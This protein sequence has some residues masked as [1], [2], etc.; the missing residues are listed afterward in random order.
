[1]IERIF[2]GWDRPIIEYACDWLLENKEL[3]PEAWIVVPTV[4]SGRSLREVLISRA[5]AMLSPH[6]TTPGLMMQLRSP[7]IATDWQE[8]YAWFEIFERIDDW[9]PYVA[10]LPDPP[11][12]SAAVLKS[13]AD[14]MLNLRRS[15]QENGLTFT[16]AARQLAHT[17]AADRWQA[18]AKLESA[19]E[20]KLSG[21]DLTSRSRAL[22]NTALIPN[23]VERIMLIGI[24]E[25]SPLLDRAFNAWQ[26]NLTSLIAA[27]PHEAA[28]FSTIG[29]PEKS[30]A[31]RELS[32]PEKPSAVHLLINP[33]KQ[34]EKV[35][36]LLSDHQTEAKHAAIGSADPEVAHAIAID[37]SRAGWS[38]FH[39]GAAVP[40]SGIRRWLTLFNQWLI[41]DSIVPLADLFSQPMTAAIVQGN[42]YDHA[43]SLAKLRDRKLCQTTAA[44]VRHLKEDTPLKF[45][46]ADLDAWR[47]R[48]ASSDLTHH[49]SELL[50][51][52]TSATPDEQNNSIKPI[53]TWLEESQPFIKASPRR[54]DFWIAWM[55]DSLPAETASPPPHRVIDVQGWLEIFH[56]PGSHLILCGMNEGSVP[57]MAGTEPWLSEVARKQLGITHQESRAARDAYL[58]HALVN[59]RSQN[60][61]IDILLGKYSASGDPLLPS[62]VLLAAPPDDLA[63]R[64]ASLFKPVE[65]DDAAIIWE[66]PFCWNVPSCDVPNQFS[67][68][69]LNDYLA[70]P[71]RFYL[72]NVLGCQSREPARKEWNLSDCGTI[73]HRVL[74]KW[75]ADPDTNTLAEADAIDNCVQKILTDLILETFGPQA[76]LAIRIQAEAIKQR[77][78]AFAEVQSQIFAEG[79]RIECVESK[80][81]FPL[82]DLTI[83]GSIDRIDCHVSSGERRVIDY[84]SGKKVAIDLKHRKKKPSP[85]S[86]SSDIHPAGELPWINLQLPL[87]CHALRTLADTFPKPCYFVLSEI[88]GE[89]SLDAWDAFNLTDLDSAVKCGLRIAESISKKSFWPPADRVDYDAFEALAAGHKFGDQFVGLNS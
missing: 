60:G 84:K 15:L 30:W 51:L 28:S 4:Q 79:W 85:Q 17:H 80:I 25:M 87:Y 66:R 27:P 70:C 3:L 89:I 6:F 46:I 88:T 5:G 49:L 64:A 45:A 61:R 10:L 42:L 47:Q 24:T 29:L 35:L 22:K 7:Q 43:K 74:E 2:L 14:E 71:F 11:E 38:A 39:P 76:P 50:T 20:E 34:A 40:L 33:K 12:P 82:G 9:K 19:V 37:L 26:G 86:S 57:K 78:K 52:L 56:Q 21:W 72:K 83:H 44:A 32:F 31:E 54:A 48:M 41:N 69:A 13:L 16:S 81:E 8:C 67:V 68:T 77:L 73:I 58:Y 36:A 63:E 59:S 62:R 23:H 53:A 1:M 18:L 55:L 65:S 75:G